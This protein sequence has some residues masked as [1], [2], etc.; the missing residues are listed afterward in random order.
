MEL[1]QQ[2]GT[3][4]EH[5]AVWAET[6]P[7]APQ[8]LTLASSLPSAVVL[9]LQYGQ[10]GVSPPHEGNLPFS[11]THPHRGGCG[12]CVPLVLPLIVVP[13]SSTLIYGAIWC[14]VIAHQYP[15]YH[16][17]CHGL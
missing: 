14:Q 13:A 6:P 1:E 16:Q 9:Q 10:G 11:A 12:D 15:I 2:E 17:A 7:K 5:S 4:A 8:T 3:E